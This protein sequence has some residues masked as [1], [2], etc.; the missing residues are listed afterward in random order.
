[1]T[2]IC[3][4]CRREGLH[5][6][7]GEKAPLDDRRETHGICVAHRSAVQARWD[8]M[9]STTHDTG[10]H[11]VTVGQETPHVAP[12]PEP[13]PRRSAAYLWVGIRN[14]TRKVGW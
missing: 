7:V 10:P 1:M 6:V 5:G 9:I 11:L 8:G 12:A 4:W 3:S 14:L 13:Q 2:I